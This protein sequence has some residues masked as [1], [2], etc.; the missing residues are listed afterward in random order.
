[1]DARRWMRPYE[2]RPS[3]A[4]ALHNAGRDTGRDPLDGAAT[5]GPAGGEVLGMLALA[6]YG[7]VPVAASA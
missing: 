6:V 1:M 5:A 2:E 4:I 7:R 3:A